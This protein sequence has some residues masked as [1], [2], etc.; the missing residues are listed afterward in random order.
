M[1]VILIIFFN[2][3]GMIMIKCI[4]EGQTVNQKYYI[5]AFYNFWQLFLIFS[6]P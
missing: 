2:I 5:E 6:V 3:K 1:K 4:P